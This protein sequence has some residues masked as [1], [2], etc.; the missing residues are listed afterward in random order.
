MRERTRGRGFTLIELLIT[1]VVIAILT[2]LAF[3]SYREHVR[4][5]RRAEAQAFLMAAAAK[6]QQFLVDTR[7][8]ATREALAMP[9]PP[10]VEAAYVIDMP[11]PAANPPSFQLTATP[12]PGTDQNQERCGTLGIDQTGAKTASG[13]RCW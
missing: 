3:P 6:Q 4:K 8:F 7:A 10:S 5:T 1:I 13:S 12:R 11:A 2:T 9:T